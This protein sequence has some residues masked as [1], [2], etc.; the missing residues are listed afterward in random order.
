MGVPPRRCAVVE[1]AA[2]GIAAAKAAG[3]AS[4]GLTGTGRSRRRLLSSGAAF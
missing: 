3:M 1:D 4:I 2:A